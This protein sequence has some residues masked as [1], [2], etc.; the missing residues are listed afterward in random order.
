MDKLAEMYK[1]MH[2]DSL[3]KDVREYRAEMSLPSRG[4]SR[5][6]KGDLDGV[7]GQLK[8]QIAY[9]ENLKPCNANGLAYPYV[10]VRVPEG[11]IKPV[12]QEEEDEESTISSMPSPAPLSSTS[13]K[14]PSILNG[15]DCDLA[16][17]RYIAD[18]L[19][20][21]WDETFQCILPFVDRLEIMSYSRN[22]ISS[23]E[24]MGKATIDLSRNSRMKR[25]LEDHQTHDTYLEMD[26]QGRILIRLTLEGGD[27]DV[28]FWFRRSRERLG[29][30]RDD[31]VRALTAKVCFDGLLF[32]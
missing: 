32:Y 28:D 15:K 3:A 14:G 6:P 22:L 26:P 8:I 4:S 1:T 18:N 9:A 30:M 21:T 25:K 23:D 7:S 13:D 19:N 2:V 29:R 5:N 24:L 27:E 11:T 17:S 20:P 12:E 10:L 31:Y 16:R